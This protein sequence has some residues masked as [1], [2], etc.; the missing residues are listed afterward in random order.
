[1]TQ[2]EAA[3]R[4]ARGKRPHL[5]QLDIVRILTFACVI[6]VHTISHTAESTNVPLIGLLILVHFTRNV[7]FALTGFVLVYSYLHHPVP[8]TKF[9]PKRFLLVG[10]PYVVWSAIYVFLTWTQAAP[11]SAFSMIPDFLHALITGTAYYHMYFVLVTMQIYLLFPLLMMLL[12]ATRG[13]HLIVLVVSGGIQML[14]SA[15]NMYAVGSLHWLHLFSNVG[16]YQ[17]FIV[18][19]AVA[20]VHADA[21]LGWVRAHPR[22][23]WITTAVTAAVTIGVYL[24]ES[25]NGWSLFGAANPV[26]PVIM[27]W[28]VAVGVWFL[29]LGTMWADRRVPGS[30]VARGVAFASD[31]SFGIFLAHPLVLWFLLWVGDDWL[32]H[33]IAKPLLTLVVYVLVV[34]GSLLIADTARRSPLSLPLAGRPFRP[35]PRQNGGGA[36][37]GSDA[38]VG[39]GTSG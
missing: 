34:A 2:P 4:P 8:L 18:L 27:V 33:T 37:R 5:Y 6:A 36:S 38:S 28:S 25:A 35:K 3:A 30:R 9:W 32:E 16:S 20:A 17:G 13:H 23:I 31:R 24:F 1:M 22:I 19:G 21:V 12:R 14:I 15:M 26:Q 29:S 11:S 10:V 7:F 39:L